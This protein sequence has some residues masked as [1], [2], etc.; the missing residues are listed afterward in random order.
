MSLVDENNDFPLPACWNEEELVQLNQVLERVDEWGWNPFE[1]SEITRM[2][3]IQALGWHL[4]SHWNV[5]EELMIDEAIMKNW[6]AFVESKYNNN[7]YH[8]AIHASDILQTVHF[9]LKT[10]N[11]SRYLT[12]KQITALLLAALVH[13]LGHDGLNNNYHKNS[14]SHRALMYN[15]QSIQENYHLF[16]LFSSMDSEEEIDIFHRLSQ[17]NFLELRKSIIDMVLF[18]DMSKHFMLLKD[19]KETCEPPDTLGDKLAAS[20]DLLMK[21]VLHVSDISNPAK[22]RELAISW[23]ERCIEEFFSQGD[24]EK[25]LGLPVSPQCNRETTSIP[26]SQIGFIEFV[27]LPSFQVLSSALPVV[28][29][30]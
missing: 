25:S 10:G 28:S 24:K 27:V 6:L 12:R 21:A 2:R 30:G 8:N 15:D 23:T 9:I 19:L 1:L 29:D 18:T 5:M 20:S 3:P 11:L 4:I 17:E 16:L 7:P 13:D 22:P 14:I 26:D